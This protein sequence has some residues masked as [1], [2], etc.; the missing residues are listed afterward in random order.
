[1][2]DGGGFHH[3]HHEGGSPARQIVRRADPGE[4]P[5]HHADARGLRRYRLAGLR[6]N[7]CQGVLA[8]EGRFAGHVRP[9]Q[10]QQAAF[11]RQIAV[12]RHEGRLSRQ[13]RFDHGMAGGGDMKGNIIRHHGPA[14]AP[15][16]R[17]F[18]G[19]LCHIQPSQRG[20]SRGDGV[21][22]CQGGGNQVG[23]HQFFPRRRPIRRFHDAAVQLHQLRVGEARAVGHAL[24]QGQI[25]V[26]AQFL[27]RHGRCLDHVAELGMV[28]DLDRGDAVALRV[29]QL[30]LGERAPRVVAQTALGIEFAVIAR[31]NGA[32]IVQ[33]H[34]RR[35]GQRRT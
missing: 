22:V 10:Q 19:R 15:G 16:F 23:K 4:Q 11:G 35:I 17:E 20:C 31:A 29:V 8:Q 26:V 21:S 9:G 25:R 30:Q 3:F 34:R 27:D 2:Q 32:A 6:Q 28:A 33:A 13:C 1:M 14:P 24:A 7:N 12:I 18:R 5:V